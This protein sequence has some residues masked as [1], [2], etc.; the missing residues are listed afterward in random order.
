MKKILVP[1]DFSKNALNAL[2]YAANFAQ[3]FNSQLVLLHTF[4]VPGRSDMLVSMDTVI[5]KD[6]EKE[7]DEMKKTVPAGISCETHVHKG[8]TPQTIARFAE[9]ENIDLIVMGT[10]GASGLKE[11]FIGSVTGSVMKLTQKPILAIP[12]NYEF[13]PIEKIVFAL[14][15]LALEGPESIE[16]LRLIAEKFNSKVEIFHHDKSASKVEDEVFEAVGWL[17]GIPLSIKLDSEGEEVNKSIKNFV[18]HSNPD[19]LC[20]VRRDRS[21]IG[22]FERLFKDSVTS[23]QVFSCEIPLLILHDK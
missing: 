5:R 10:Q 16:Y 23:T 20:L 19:L 17:K 2:N 3:L 6:A 11:V 1:T 21:T 4:Q 7:M 8:N 12:E 15:N 9:N 13:R 22:F 14:A 18:E